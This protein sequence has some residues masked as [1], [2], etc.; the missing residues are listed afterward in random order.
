MVHVHEFSP[1]GPVLAVRPFCHTKDYWQVYFDTNRCIKEGFG[2]AKF[3]P[4]Q[5]H[6]AIANNWPMSAAADI[7]KANAVAP[8]AAH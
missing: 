2:E 6:F 7:L 5:Q 4:P 1:M 8:D 3:A